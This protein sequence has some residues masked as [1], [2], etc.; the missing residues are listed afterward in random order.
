MQKWGMEIASDQISLSNS[1]GGHEKGR[2]PGERR[3]EPP[4]LPLSF[5]SSSCGAKVWINDAYDDVHKCVQCAYVMFCNAPVFHWV[6]T[7]AI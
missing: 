7:R 6:S 5:L 1:A 4:R 2:Q 3:Q